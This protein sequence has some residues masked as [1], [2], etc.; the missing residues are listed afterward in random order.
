V[1]NPRPEFVIHMHT[2]LDIPKAL[3]LL[4]EKPPVDPIATLPMTPNAVV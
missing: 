3:A 2:H 4:P 1:K